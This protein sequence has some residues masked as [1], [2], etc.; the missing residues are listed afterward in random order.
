MIP[1]EDAFTL[2]DEGNKAFAEHDWPR[3]VECYTQAIALNDKEPSFY[4]NRA[5]VHH[6]SSFQQVMWLT[7]Q[8]GK[9]KARGIWLRGGRCYQG[10]RA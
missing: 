4:C 10:H 8:L 5:Q 6:Y 1:A 2:K 9:Y 3:A 7:A